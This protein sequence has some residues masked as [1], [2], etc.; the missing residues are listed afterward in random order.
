MDRYLERA[1][2]LRAELK[3]VAMDDHNW[4]LKTFDLNGQGVVKLWCAER[5]KD[6]EGSSKDHMKSQIDNLF[7]NFRRS[8][9]VSLQHVRNYCAAKNIDFDDHLQSEAKN[10]RAVTVTLEDHKNLIAKGVQIMEGVNATL[11]DGLKKFTVLGNFT[12]S[13]TRCYWFKV[14]CPYCRELMV[15]CPPRK[16]L[17]VNLRNHL[18]GFKHQK[19]VEDAD[20]ETREPSKTGRPGRPTR[21]SAASSLSNQGDLNS[22]IRRTSSSGLQGTSESIDHNVL[23]S[24]MCYGFRGPIVSYGGNFYPVRALLDDPHSGVLWYPEPE[25]IASVHV[26]KENV[27]VRGTFRH[28]NCDRLAIGMQPFVNLTCCKCALIPLQHDFRMRVRREESAL[29]KRGHHSTALGIRLDYLFVLEVSRHT[30]SLSKKFRL[31]KL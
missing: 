23:A 13:D 16:T 25:L 5:K 27:E 19:A 2:K 4:W 30:R 17:D 9:I 26:R 1:K 28:R 10:G 31:Q 29:L 11:A 21:S 15:L 6:C 18:V 24:L 20:Q 14:K 3:R 8:H 22:W 7:N 12:S